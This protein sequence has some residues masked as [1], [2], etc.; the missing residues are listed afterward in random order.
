MTDKRAPSLLGLDTSLTGT[1]WARSY[2]DGRAQSGTWHLAD[3]V[4]GRAGAFCTLYRR[5]NELHADDPLDAIA[6]EQPLKLPVD[7]VDKLI[8]LLGLVAHVESWAKSRRVRVRGVQQGDWRKTFLPD[9]AKGAGR[10]GWKRAAIERARQLDFNPLSDDEAEAVGVLDHL[11]HLEGH[12][13][14]WR[15]ANPFLECV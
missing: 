8:A 5:L 2:G 10:D 9:V 7:S 6:Y 13:P 15:E 11:A 4:A 3:N 14:Q 1:G 12:K